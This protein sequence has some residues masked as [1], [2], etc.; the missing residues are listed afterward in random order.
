MNE[1]V[2]VQQVGGVRCCD[3]DRERT[4]KRLRDAAGEG[5]L[6]M[7]DLEERLTSAYAAKY[8]HELDMLVLDLPRATPH[9]AAAWLAILATM[10]TQL[11]TDA[12]LLFGRHT[13]RSSRRRTA[14]AVVAVLALLGCAVVGFE[15]FEPVDFDD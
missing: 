4:S 9:R 3:A 12:A 14:I 15:L 8:G 11:R 13:A 6:T 7:D 1:P 10:W 5:Y 2:P